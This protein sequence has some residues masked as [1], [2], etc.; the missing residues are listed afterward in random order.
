MFYVLFYFHHWAGGGKACQ[1]Y[2]QNV[3]PEPVRVAADHFF[4]CSPVD[5]LHLHAAMPQTFVNAGLLMR[6]QYSCP[7]RPNDFE[8]L[9]PGP[10]GVKII[11]F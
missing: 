2:L 9:M 4:E 1:T 10:V 8:R 6:N 7:L 5:G 3:F 11:E